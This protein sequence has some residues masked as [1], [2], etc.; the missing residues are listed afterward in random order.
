MISARVWAE[1]ADSEPAEYNWTSH[2][3]GRYRFDSTMSS[4]LARNGA[5]IQNL[6]WRAGGDVVAV[7][8]PHEALDNAKRGARSEEK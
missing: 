2:Q 8:T 3:G 6:N 1:D 4:K 7:A 5:G